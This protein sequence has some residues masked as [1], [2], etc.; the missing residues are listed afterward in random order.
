MSDGFRE[1][2]RD[3]ARD[4]AARA[5]TA[6][7]RAP[8]AAAPDAVAPDAGAPEPRPA[9]PARRPLR[10][11]LR[12]RAARALGHL[13]PA[14]QLRLSGEPPVAVD[15]LTLD[16]QLQLLRALARRRGAPGLVEPTVE[17][18]RLRYRREMQ[19]LAG[20]PVPVGA[21]H[22]LTIPGAA[23][24]LAA[25][26]YAPPRAAGDAPAPLLV[27]LH[28]GGFVIGD[29]ETHDLPCRLLC[30]DAGQHVLSVAYRLAPEHPFPAGLDD[31]CVALRW[32][33]AHAAALGADPARVTIGGD[34]AGGTLATVA[35]RLAARAGEPPLAQLLVYPAV[36]VAPGVAGDGR[37]PRPS[38]RLFAEGFFLSMRDRLAFGRHYVGR[39]PAARGLT[40]PDD[41]RIAPLRA[42]DL[43]GLPPALVVTAGFDVLRDEGEAYAAALAAAGTPA[44]LLRVAAFGHGFLHV[45]GVSRAAREAMRDVAAAWRAVV[46]AAAADTAAADAAAANAVGGEPG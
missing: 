46:D 28:G 23:G 5:V 7:G 36:D 4:R 35:A 13:P 15:G 21:V 39:D 11:R 1:A 42:P 43:G 2:V 34:S 40:R 45:A 30:R 8:D 12:H 31:A 44:R 24:P 19:A 25:R 22:E 41:P 37:A 26:H 29:L 27:W 3:A 33:R 20:P 10:D 16:P 38:E 18:G 6:P 9:A 14:L 32:A 17:A